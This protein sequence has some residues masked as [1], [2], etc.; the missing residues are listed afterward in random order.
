MAI[1]AGLLSDSFLIAR[2]LYVDQRR[3][4]A[5]PSCLRQA[6]VPTRLD[7]IAMHSFA[8]DGARPECRLPLLGADERGRVLRLGARLVGHSHVFVRRALL[9][10]AGIGFVPELLVRQDVRHGSLRRLLLA[11]ASPAEEIHLVY[12]SGRLLPAKIRAFLDFA[13][14]NAGQRL[15]QP[16]GAA[17]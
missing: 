2:Q 11:W 15:S 7:E 1:Q 5:S 3:F 10:G 14:A 6:G 16:D 13:R 9:G 4:D 17:A 8:S 12:P